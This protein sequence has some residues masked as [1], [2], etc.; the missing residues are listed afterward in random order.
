MIFLK[1]FSL[2]NKGFGV[3][4]NENGSFLIFFF[5]N[6]F[7]DQQGFWSSKKRKIV[8]IDFLKTLSLKNK[9]FGVLKNEKFAFLIFFKDFFVDKQGFWSS[10]N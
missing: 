4:K 1:T 8:F 9:G 3:L 7:V 2:K 10:K 5:K 6:I